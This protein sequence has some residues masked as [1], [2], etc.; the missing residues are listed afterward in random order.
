M[1]M[2]ARILVI[3]ALLSPVVAEANDA[4]VHDAGA[5]VGSGS[6]LPDAGSA[7]APVVTPADKIPDPIAH[8]AQAFDELKAA[9]KEGWSIAAFA[10]LLML[11]KAAA[12]L[13][14]NVR[15]LAVLGKGKVAIVIGAVGALAASC[16]NAA[17]EGGAWTAMLMA[18]AV[19]VFAHLDLGEK[20]KA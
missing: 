8:P 15:W 4:G 10:L 17:A 5:L 19:A 20:T 18:G 12:R 7:S 9:K 16:Y 3:V 6:V 2:L 11:A 13:G 1:T 14:K